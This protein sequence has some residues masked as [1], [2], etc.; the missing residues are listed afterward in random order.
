MADYSIITNHGSLIYVQTNLNAPRYKVITMDLSTGEPEIRDFIPELE[1]AKLAQVKCINKEYF[2]V[3]YKR[4]VS[5]PIFLNS[6]NGVITPQV[7]DEIYLYS[8]AG[9]QVTRLAPDFVGV[10]S[11]ANREK[12]PHFFL[13]VS[14]FNCSL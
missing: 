3:I 4:N 9:V 6:P 11:I 13:T 7:K 5:L 14:G 10:A 1:D 8:K 12:Q 2:V